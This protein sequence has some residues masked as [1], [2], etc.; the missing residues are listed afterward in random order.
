MGTNLA[1]FASVGVG[2]GGHFVRPLIV[3]RTTFLAIH[4]AR[5]VRTIAFNHIFTVEIFRF[6]CMAAA[7]QARTNLDKTQ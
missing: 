4:A 6:V 3:Q 1:L 5:I 2:V 7:I